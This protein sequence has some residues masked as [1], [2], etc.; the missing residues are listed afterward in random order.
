METKKLN[1]L[2]ISEL[3]LIYFQ[4]IKDEDE[5]LKVQEEINKRIVNCMLYDTVLEENI[6][7]YE[8]FPYHERFGYNNYI[9]YK[10]S[11][12]QNLFNFFFRYIKEANTEECMFSE[13][14]IARNFKKLIKLEMKNIEIRLKD[15]NDF[16][17]IKYLE[18]AYDIYEMQIKYDF[19]DIYDYIFG[20][21]S[22]Y[23][24]FK[25]EIDLLIEKET[26]LMEPKIKR[27]EKLISNGLNKVNYENVEIVD[28]LD[29]EEQNNT[30]KILEFK[31]K[32]RQK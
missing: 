16:N 6:Y 17:K 32:V 30:G 24:R 26:K 22:N 10:N 7:D 9:F 31:T 28:F 25:T 2:G 23:N 29:L 27:Y 21:N 8:F 20:L 15:K 13:L 18:S 14:I 11:S 3:M 4:S 5:N 12:V 19:E 1:K